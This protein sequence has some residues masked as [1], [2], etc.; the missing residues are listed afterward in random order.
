MRECIYLLVSGL[1][2]KLSGGVRGARGGHSGHVGF[3]KPIKG[4]LSTSQ[5]CFIL[6]LLFELTVWL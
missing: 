5:T 3:N 2:A 1:G 6:F 4:H